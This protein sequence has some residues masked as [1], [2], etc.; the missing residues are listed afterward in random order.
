MTKK[1]DA[2][3]R[4]RGQ[5]LV[6]VIMIMLVLLI[7]VPALVQ[8]AQIESKASTGGNNGST[9][10]NLAEAAVER[11][12]W[13]IQ[14]ST[15]AWNAASTGTAIAGYNF[16]TTYM[17]VAGGMYRIKITSAA[18][19]SATV[20][21]EGRDNTK[22]QTRQISAVFQNQTIYS[23]LMAGGAVNLT[24]S[25]CPFWGPI[26]AH[27]NINLEDNWAANNYYPRKFA[28]GVVLCDNV[29]GT[30]NA[31]T[32]PRDSN[33]LT[34][35]NTDGKEWW[36][37]YQQIP[38]LP[39]LDFAALRSSAAATGTLNVYGCASSVT[40][41]STVTV[42]GQPT[43]GSMVA[44]KAPWDKRTR[45][46]NIQTLGGHSEHF[47]VSENHPL[48]TKNLP[49]NSYVWYWDGNVTLGGVT[50]PPTSAV[51]PSTVV[52][53]LNGTII[54]RGNLT[55]DSGGNYAYTGHV[56]ANAWA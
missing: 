27:G 28:H 38:P 39:I 22:K 51:Y 29:N 7:M 1:I 2:S 8:W 55:F 25:M 42:L 21:G 48:G 9:A 41:M 43:F 11:G 53:G 54:V 17:D 5:V 47:S 14:S 49:N 26:M 23:P 30:C 24:V 46:S 12:Y 16:D 15:T 35:P 37:D 13:K 10:F 20:V 50:P 36:S 6:G 19:G 3:P 45:C 32:N 33:G 40:H 44:G 56:P 31:A 34:P 4:K 52:V 18:N